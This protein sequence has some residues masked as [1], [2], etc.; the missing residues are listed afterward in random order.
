MSDGP[1]ACSFSSRLALVASG[2]EFGRD[3]ETFG[4]VLGFAETADDAEAVMDEGTESRGTPHSAHIR[5]AAGLRPG[6]LRYA[7]TSH[8][9]LS[10]R[11]DSASLLSIPAAR[12]EDPGSLSD[13]TR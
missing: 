7:H 9:Q 6:G 10:K 1:S 4:E 3:V 12:A 8:S 2:D 11:M 5:A 13:T